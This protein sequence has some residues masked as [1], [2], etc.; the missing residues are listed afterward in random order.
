ME[1]CEVILHTHDCLHVHQFSVAT[2]WIIMQTWLLACMK[3]ACTFVAVQRV[4]QSCCLQTYCFVRVC[5]REITCF[6]VHWVLCLSSGLSPSGTSVA[7][8]PGSCASP[9][10]RPG[11]DQV[12]ILV[13]SAGRSD[14]SRWP[15]ARSPGLGYPQICCTST[16][17][18][19]LGFSARSLF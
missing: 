15:G 18:G 1:P 12:Q 6:T 9:E 19:L 16:S 11:P 17:S 5:D 13:A 3:S 4:H 10:R 2:V 7:V 8:A 14:Q